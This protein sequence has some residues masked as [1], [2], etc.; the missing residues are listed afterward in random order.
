MRT[1]PTKMAFDIWNLVR[2]FGCG[3]WLRLTW[4]VRVPNGKFDGLSRREDKGFTC[5]NG[6][7]KSFDAI[8][9]TADND[10]LRTD[11]IFI[12]L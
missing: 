11:E 1:P 9:Y 4:G 10:R 6:S 2:M 5:G 8:L 12:L 3:S 7:F